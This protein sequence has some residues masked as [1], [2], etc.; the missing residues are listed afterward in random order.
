MYNSSIYFRDSTRSS[1]VVMDSNN[2]NSSIPRRSVED[3]DADNEQSV[4]EPLVH[5][6]FSDDDSIL[7]SNIPSEFEIS[8][9]TDVIM[10][11]YK[12]S[13]EPDSVH[14]S[15]PTEYP[16]E[17]CVDKSHCKDDSSV[18]SADEETYS[19]IQINPVA[20]AHTNQESSDA[21]NEQSLLG[22]RVDHGFGD[23]KKMHPLMP[24]DRSHPAGSMDF[25][26]PIGHDDRHTTTD[27]ETIDEDVQS[28]DII[29]AA[30][31]VHLINRDHVNPFA[32]V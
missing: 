4:N 16:E 13:A 3:C 28:C 9:D 2:S 20:A 7:N 11:P 17:L 1:V 26:F 25:P 18:F 8:N 19:S 6:I 22:L 31:L 23:Y 29:N 12:R 21:D 14:Q 10:E 15:S 32:M 30:E 27:D 24:S 5:R